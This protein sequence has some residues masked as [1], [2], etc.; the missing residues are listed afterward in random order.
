MDAD[1]VLHF[2]FE[3]ID[4][5]LWFRKD[6]QFDR[7]IKAKFLAL[8]EQA[9]SCELSTWRHTAHGALAEILVLDQFSR[10]IFRDSPQA[11]ASDPL[12]LGLAQEAVCRKFDAELQLRQR[13]FLYMPFMHS[14]SSVI[15][16]QAEAL[17]SHPGLEENLRFE[18]RHKEI[19]D[20]FGRYP[21]RN[22][23]L[24]RESTPEEIE[25]LKGAGS[26]F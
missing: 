13:A 4:P 14:E 10:N 24:G 18:L 20:R 3:E 22:A 7:L 17:F 23:I 12:A 11:F 9:H 15:H 6:A 19:I 1:G 25:F 16:Q 26:S 2:W 8:H 5:R 21:H